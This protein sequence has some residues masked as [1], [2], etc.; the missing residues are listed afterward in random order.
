[1]LALAPAVFA[2]FE[3]PVHSLVH[4]L[5]PPKPVAV[6]HVGPPK[7]GSTTLQYQLLRDADP[8]D[9]VQPDLFAQSKA[10]HEVHAVGQRR[11][12]PRS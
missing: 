3:H 12:G 10:E 11:D 1:M 9:V 7:T 5:P 8:V 4:E 2:P 6:V